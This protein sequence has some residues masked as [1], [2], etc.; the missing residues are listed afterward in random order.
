M[1][2]DVTTKELNK[3]LFDCVNSIVENDPLASIN[4]FVRN[5]NW[6]YKK[7]GYGL[8]KWTDCQN[9]S[10]KLIATNLDLLDFCVELPSNN[11]IM[12]Y[13]HDFPWVN[14]K[15]LGKKMIKLLTNPKISVYSRLDYIKE[16]VN[17]F[18]KNKDCKVESLDTLIKRLLY[19][20]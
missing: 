18:R 12:L 15:I 19:E 2:E 9:F 1:I 8:F 13:C 10:G 16:V 17:T 6:P 4:I 20:I 11:D 7:V 3:N 5:I 14:S